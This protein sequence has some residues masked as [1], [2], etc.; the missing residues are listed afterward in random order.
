M[1]FYTVA[2]DIQDAFYLTGGSCAHVLLTFMYYG[3]L[4]AIVG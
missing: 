3:L 2:S 1:S 4:L